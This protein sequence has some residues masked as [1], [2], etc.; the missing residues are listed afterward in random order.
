MKSLVE[1]Q[2]TIQIQI[3]LS[4]PESAYETPTIE[5]FSFRNNKKNIPNEIPQVGPGEGQVYA[6]LTTNS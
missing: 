3:I 2:E 6:Y 4:H 5:F 1:R